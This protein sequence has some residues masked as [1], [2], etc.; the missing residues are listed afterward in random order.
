MNRQEVIALMESSASQA[1]WDENSNRVCNAC[2]GFPSY[3]YD[4]IIR[5]GVAEQTR[6]RYLTAENSLTS[7]V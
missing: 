3:W 7:S 5:S 1:E 4:V 6:N 2:G